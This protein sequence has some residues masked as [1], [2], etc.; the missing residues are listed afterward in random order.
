MNEPQ[1]NLSYEQWQARI[2][3]LKSRIRAVQLMVEDEI[4]KGKA[5]TIKTA[6]TFGED[7]SGSQLQNM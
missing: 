6:K 1:E 3:M 4:Q 5:K 7:S 2:L